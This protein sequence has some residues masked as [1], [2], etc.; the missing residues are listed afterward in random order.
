MLNSSSSSK[1]GTSISLNYKLWKFIW[2]IS[3]P[4]K[5]KH[6]WWR[7]C[8]YATYSWDNLII[9]KCIQSLF[10]SIWNLEVETIEHILCRCSWV[11]DVWKA[12]NLKS[13]TSSPSTTSL[14]SW[15]SYWLDSGMETSS[16]VELNLVYSLLMRRKK[17]PTPLLC[18]GE[19][20]NLLS[21]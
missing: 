7:C 4:P 5:L 17:S 11:R 3:C 10:C 16:S 15:F 21:A 14:L 20:F 9:R 1:F 13:V 2:N 8:Q 6:F 18:I 12:C 19:R